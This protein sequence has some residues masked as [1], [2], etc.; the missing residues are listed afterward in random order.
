MKS[1]KQGVKTAQKTTSRY[2]GVHWNSQAKK[3]VAS[4]YI[5]P[6]NRLGDGLFTEYIGAFDSEDEA[7]K[8][9]NARAIEL[10]GENARL[11]VI[12]EGE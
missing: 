6:K 8:A 5:S 12:G 9:Y 3:W 7:A 1:T 11:N 2:V 10:L 4:L